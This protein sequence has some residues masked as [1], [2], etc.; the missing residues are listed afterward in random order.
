VTEIRKAGPGHQSHIARADHSNA[1]EKPCL[2]WLTKPQ[3]HGGLAFSRG[4]GTARV[5]KTAQQLYQ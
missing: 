3:F 5:Q 4:E 1:H 2:A